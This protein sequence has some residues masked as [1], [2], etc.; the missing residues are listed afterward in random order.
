MLVIIVMGLVVANLYYFRSPLF[1][2]EVLVNRLLSA[3][4][5]SGLFFLIWAGSRG[6]AMGFGDVKLVLVMGLILGWP[7]LLFALYIAFLTGAMAGVILI[8]TGR[9]KMRST[10]SFG[11]F[12]ILG[13]LITSLFQSS[14]LQ[15]WEGFI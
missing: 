5:G 7:L 11:P 2:E 1:P 8:L 3:L 14:L 10:I 9:K 13:L 4:F 15:F 12:L 6:R